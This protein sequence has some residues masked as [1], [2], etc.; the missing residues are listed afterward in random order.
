[1]R[2]GPGL[3]A[4]PGGPRGLLWVSPRC[5]IWCFSRRYARPRSTCRGAGQGVGGE[6]C[7]GA[8]LWAGLRARPERPRCVGQLGDSLSG[9]GQWHPRWWE[10]CLAHLLSP[11]RPALRPTPP[12]APGP[13]RAR[14]GARPRQ[15]GCEPL[16]GHRASEVALPPCASSVTGLGAGLCPRPPKTGGVRWLRRHGR[17][18]ARHGAG[19]AAYLGPRTRVCGAGRRSPLCTL[20]PAARADA[21]APFCSAGAALPRATWGRQEQ[22]PSAPAHSPRC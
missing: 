13:R 15:Q 22:H 7:G 2:R 5:M 9:G 4:S 11:H 12:G 6:G 21:L 3:P 16:A 10:R 1:M 14:R 8:L 20:R 17:E 19:R 18:E